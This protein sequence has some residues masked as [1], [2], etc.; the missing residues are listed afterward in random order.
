[1]PPREF[2]RYTFTNAA[3]DS[4][5]R[6]VLSSRERFRFE[7][8][9]DNRTHLVIGGDTLFNL[10]NRRFK[11]L[12]R[13]AGLYWVIAD[14]QPEP[15]HDPTLRLEPGT[16][17]IVPSVQTVLNRVFSESERRAEAFG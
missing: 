17:L 5:G 3:L 13:P 2:S 9:P 16:V 1:M 11:P 14:F 6:L 7:Q 10:A 4:A 15:I 12:P 8:L